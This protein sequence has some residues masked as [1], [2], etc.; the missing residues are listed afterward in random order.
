MTKTTGLA[1]P[2]K[3]LLSVA[4][5]T[6]L[7]SGYSMANSAPSSHTV[8]TGVVVTGTNF[9]E[10]ELD[11]ESKVV[12]VVSKEEMQTKRPTSVVEAMKEVPGINFSRAGGLG[13]Q[14]VMRGFNSNDLKVPMAI[15]GERFRGRNTLEYNLID[16]ESIERIEVIRGPAAAIY[17]SES[18]AGMVNIVTKKPKPNFSDTFEMKLSGISAGFESVN[19]LWGVRAEVEGGGRGVDMR[20]GLSSR[21]AG[22]YDTPQGK[23]IHS[24]FESKQIDGEIG[25]SFNKDDRLALRFKVAE[26]VSHRAGGLGGAPGMAAPLAQRVYLR[27]DP[28]REDYVGLNY[29][30]KPN[31]KGIAKVEASLYNRKLNTDVVTTRFPNA[32]S[33]NETHRYVIGPDMTGGKVMVVS[34]AV[35]NTIIT[36]GVDFFLQDWKGAETERRG[37]GTV[38]STARNKLESDASQKGLGA[39]I[40]AE[41]ELNDQWLISG[42]LRHDHYDTKT[43]ADVITIPALMDTIRANKNSSNS[44]TTY[45]VGTVFKPLTWLNFAANYGTSFRVPTTSELFGY[46][47]YGTGYLVPNPTLK[48]EEGQTIDFSARLRFDRLVSN[49]TFYRSNYN[50]LIG[51][52]EV[53]HLGLPSSRRTN[54]GKATVEGVELEMAYAL[55]NQWSLKLA[56]AYTEGTDDTTNRPLAYIAP[57]MSSLGVRYDTGN[58]YV[59]ADVRHSS[60]KDRIDNKQERMTDGY[61]VLDL[62]A[63]AKL[64][65][66]SSDLPKNTM[67][68]VGIENV[69]DET[70]VNPTTREAITSANSYTNPLIEP[71]RNVKVSVTSKF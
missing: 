39:F 11:D 47:T 41:H 17:G 30:G 42:N 27:E 16:P 67:L 34:D 29:T 1:L 31:I 20:L 37:T 13:G 7:F 8:M 49:L 22:D 40:L 3:T 18:M 36:T 68:R 52:E 56:S 48:P 10:T 24:G 71:G 33:I 57:L 64:S 26:V 63:G 55:T 54:I 51:R 58:Y 14:V 35:K 59:Q 19:N 15:N 66:F 60:K 70:Y 53:T 21:S 2:S 69:F 32:T 12:S 9:R 5:S 38:S 28:I 45:A 4:V 46:G 23:A 50:N 62:Y 61:T 44:S 43:D 65:Q 25:Y 6:L